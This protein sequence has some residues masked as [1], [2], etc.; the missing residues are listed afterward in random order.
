MT[1]LVRQTLFEQAAHALIAAMRSPHTRAAYAADLAR[2]I[3]FA[4][5]A[6]FDPAS[7]TLMD[8]TSGCRCGFVHGNPPPV[9][10]SRRD[11]NQK[12]DDAIARELV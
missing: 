1:A 11:Y 6:D 8:A 7:A 10:T 5:V 12:H 3:A 4:R 9:R 2:W